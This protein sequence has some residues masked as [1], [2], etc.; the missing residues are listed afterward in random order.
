MGVLADRDTGL[1]S[2]FALSVGFTAGRW[3]AEGLRP[4]RLTVVLILLACLPG[5][6]HAAQ[7]QDRKPVDAWLG[8]SAMDFDYKE[9]VNGERLD[10]EHGTL[11][12]LAAGVQA[13]VLE[14]CFN[15]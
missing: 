1:V 10:H 5:E 14:G 2:L 4:V 15:I 11:Y 6:T 8:P 12:G 13:G 7:D 9:Y 3:G